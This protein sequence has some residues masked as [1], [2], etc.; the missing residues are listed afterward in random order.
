MVLH[1]PLHR[2]QVRRVAH[3]HR[4][5]D[6]VLAMNRRALAT[7]LAA[8]LEIVMDQE[9]VVKELDRDGRRECLALA[10]AE[11]TA[12][13]HAESGAQAFSPAPGIRRDQVVQIR[14]ASA[15][16]KLEQRTRAQLAVTRQRLF[17]RLSV[18][19]TA[20]RTLSSAVERAV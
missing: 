19:S 13:G 16:N 17:E 15:R 2:E 5:A 12:S 18:G 10:P 4:D 3:V 8:V 14:R 7:A 11:R 20:R 9:S 1:E 6:A